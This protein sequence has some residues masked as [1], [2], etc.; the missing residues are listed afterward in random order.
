MGAEPA[1]A[2]GDGVSASSRAIRDDLIGTVCSML[3]GLTFDDQG[4]VA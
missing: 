1:A 4:A 2:P 3:D